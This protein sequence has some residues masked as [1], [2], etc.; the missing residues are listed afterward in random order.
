MTYPTSHATLGPGELALNDPD[1]YVHE[2][3]RNV[4]RAMAG[5]V[6]KILRHVIYMVLM[7][8]RVPLQLVSHTLFFP[9]VGFGIFWGFVAGWKSP[10]CLWMVG[11]GIGLYVLT[12][13]FD[14]LLL[15]VSPEQLHLDA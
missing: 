9:L 15:W 8:V 6:W 2:P 1:F 5:G 7:L 13:L 14:T 3:R 10:A 11:T 12:F 4:G